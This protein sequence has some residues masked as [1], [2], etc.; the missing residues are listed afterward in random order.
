LKIWLK[1]I[2]VGVVIFFVGVFYI[3]AQGGN[4]ATNSEGML[5]S[6]VGFFLIIIGVVAGI[7]RGVRR[8]MRE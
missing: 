3:T 1:V 2:I 7:V 4:I 6:S 8:M 5:I